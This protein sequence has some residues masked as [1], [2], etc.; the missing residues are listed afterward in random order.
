MIE[1]IPK[2]T[3]TKVGND[4]SSYDLRKTPY[5]LEWN[6]THMASKVWK[7]N[8]FL[9]KYSCLSSKKQKTSLNQNFKNEYESW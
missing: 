8:M 9:R 6:R 1:Q 5:K 2:T 3:D 4:D 7:G